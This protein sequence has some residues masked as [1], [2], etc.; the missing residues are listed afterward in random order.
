MT[1]I[2]YAKFVNNNLQYAPRTITIGQTHYNP[3]PETWLAENGYLP[4]VETPYPDD[5]KYYAGSWVEQDGQIV[6]TWTETEGPETPATDTEVLN[7]M[8]GVSE[9]G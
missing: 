6:R 4:V 5:G 8:I 9:D 1:S 3:T 7:A 2:R